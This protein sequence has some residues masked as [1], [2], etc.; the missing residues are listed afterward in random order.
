VD[1]RRSFVKHELSSSATPFGP[2]LVVVVEVFV[3]QRQGEHALLEQFLD[4]VLDQLRISEVVEAAGECQGRP[5]LGDDCMSRISPTGR[6][7]AGSRW[8]PPLPGRAASGLL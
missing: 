8:P 6:R 4:R 3:T 1:W 7:L 2:Q 5:A